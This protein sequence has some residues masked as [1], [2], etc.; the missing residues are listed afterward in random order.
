MI[1]YV[2][3]CSSSNN[4]LCGLCEGDCDSDT[5]CEG[6]LV[7]MTRNDIEPVIGCSGEGGPR[8]VW[9]CVQYVFF[10]YYVFLLN[11]HILLFG[12]QGKDVCF[13][14]NLVVFPD[15]LTISDIEC[16]QSNECLR[17]EGGCSSDEDCAGDLICFDRIGL[18]SVPYCVTGELGEYSTLNFIFPNDDKY[19]FLICFISPAS[20]GPIGDISGTNYCSLE[21]PNGDATYIPGDL[22]GQ[23]DPYGLDLSTGLQGRLIAVKHTPVAFANGSFSSANFHGDPDGAAVFSVNTG[24]NAGG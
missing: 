20:F 7:C 19:L 13:N 16:S 17:C 4:Y 10:F 22:D 18:E 21:L 3:E 24:Q 9:V 1:N 15:S 6:D 12:H 2:G 11:Q 23:V 14:P 5:D 8:D